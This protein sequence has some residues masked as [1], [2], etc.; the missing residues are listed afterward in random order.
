MWEKNQRLII[1][2]N[3]LFNLLHE[4]EDAFVSLIGDNEFLPEKVLGISSDIQKKLYLLYLTTPRIFLLLGLIDSH[5][6]TANIIKSY[7]TIEFKD[8]YSDLVESVVSNETQ[9]Q[10]VFKNFINFFGKKGL[11][12]VLFALN[13]CDYNADVQLQKW[14]KICKKYSIALVDFELIRVYR[15]YLDLEVLSDVE[16]NKAVD[17]ILNMDMQ[18]LAFVFGKIENEQKGAKK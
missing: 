11:R 4:E 8:I 13:S 10:Y 7:V 15:R 18:G 2:W 9:Q 16:K 1:E 3:R 5:S 6:P 12:D 14:D 17:A